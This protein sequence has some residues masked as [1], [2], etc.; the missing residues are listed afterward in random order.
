[1]ELDAR[2]L[3]TLGGMLISVVSAAVIVRQKLATVVEQLADVE[4]RLRK[5]DTHVDR[6]N[7]QLEMQGQRTGVLS[8]MLDPSNR[9]RLHRSLERMAAE[10]DH[11]RKDCDRLYS[12]H[13]GRHQAA[14][15]AAERTE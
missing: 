11:L 1:M 9:E 15:D 14:G 7:T 6:Q 3:L 13:N 8:K 5:M 4:Q 2:L 12:L 10:I